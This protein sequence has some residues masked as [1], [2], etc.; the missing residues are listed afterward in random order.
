MFFIRTQVSEDAP[1]FHTEIRISH[2]QVVELPNEDPFMQ[3]DKKVLGSNDSFKASCTV[4]KSYPSANITWYINDRKVSTKIFIQFFASLY[5]V[6]LRY[7]YHLIQVNYIS[8][9]SIHCHLF[10]FI[11]NRKF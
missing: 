7:F 1:L 3:I 9:I 2:M 10:C 8:S 4:G 5:S 6:H 11:K